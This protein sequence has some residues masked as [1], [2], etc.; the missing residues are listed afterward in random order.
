MADI[1]SQTEIDAL[2]DISI[3]DNEWPIIFYISE[4]QKLLELSKEYVTEHYNIDMDNVYEHQLKKIVSTIYKVDIDSI[5]SLPSKSA[6][7]M[8]FQKKLQVFENLE[9]EKTYLEDW[10]NSNPEYIL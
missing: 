4:A 10:L 8:F 2:L 1:L 9:K 3:G 5:E 7:A 6:V